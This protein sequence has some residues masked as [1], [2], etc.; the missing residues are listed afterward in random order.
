MSISMAS[1][2]MAST[3]ET[4]SRSGGITHF[5]TTNVDVAIKRISSLFGPHQIVPNST[6]REISFEHSFV[7]L[8]DICINE[9]AYGAELRND[10]GEFAAGNY[11]VMFPLGG[12]YAIT[13]D[14]RRIEGDRDTV[15]IINPNRPV[16]LEAS[17]DYRN[18]SVSLTKSAIDSALAN[19]LGRIP[20][21]PV[22]FEPHPQALTGGSEPVRNLVMQLWGECQQHATHITFD[23][24][25]R[26]LETL[27]ASMVLLR[28]PNNYSALLSEES[29][30]RP[31]AAC[32]Q[33]ANFLKQHA[34][35]DICLEDVV[36]ASGMARTSLYTEF[37]KHYGVTPM[38]YLRQE[39]LRLAH[40]ILST[41]KL[42]SVSVTTVAMDCGFNHFSRFASYYK[43]QYGELP[44]ETL[45]R[46]IQ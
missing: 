41:A 45:A 22:T 31:S 39:R 11:C 7:W 19:H 29:D 44:S 36:G 25:G 9:L 2:N 4:M 8:R 15:T 18:I 37:K 23:A 14:A 46:K 1:N 27:L 3:S 5:R 28:V 43:N 35:E 16:T 33:T 17:S 40:D 34:R 26:E 10:I 42:T 32:K 12:D 6:R 21:A 38:E 30:A 20:H 24:V 13:S